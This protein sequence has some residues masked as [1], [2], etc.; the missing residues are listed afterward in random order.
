MHV[1][2]QGLEDVLPPPPWQHRPPSGLTRTPLVQ[3]PELQSQHE[4]QEPSQHWE[5]GTSG[6]RPLV[7]SVL[8]V[9]T[10]PETAP[11][12]SEEGVYSKHHEYL[13][14]Y[15]ARTEMS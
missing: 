7:W 13:N 14:V 12:V 1:Q 11:S 6:T 4:G 9:Q 5:H 2:L 8:P 10:A 15:I 3:L